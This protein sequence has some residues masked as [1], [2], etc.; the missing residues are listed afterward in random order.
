M[1]G[2]AN[3]HTRLKQHK[4]YQLVRSLVSSMVL[5]LLLTVYC[6]YLTISLGLNY[7]FCVIEMLFS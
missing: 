7:E 4:R 1:G 2:A 3:G 5:I 6:S